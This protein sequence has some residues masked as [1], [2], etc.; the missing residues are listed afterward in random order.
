GAERR[1]RRPVDLVDGA[2]WPPPRAHRREGEELIDRYLIRPALFGRKSEICGN[3][4]ISITPTISA[5]TEGIEE[6]Q[7]WPTV[8]LANRSAISRP[9]PIGGR[10]RPMPTAAVCTMLQWMGSIHISF[11]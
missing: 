6:S 2:G 5:A 10:K 9:T 1:G 4:M 11:G 8:R 3:R 7:C